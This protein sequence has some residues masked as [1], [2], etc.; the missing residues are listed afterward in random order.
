MGR[1]RQRICISESYAGDLSATE[2]LDDIFR[3]GDA[4]VQD[5]KGSHFLPVFLGGNGSDLHIFHAFQ[6]IEEFLQLTGVDVFSSPD[7][8]SLMRPV[9]R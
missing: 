9:M 7:N 6:V 2:V 4:F 1:C 3:H 5:D 8:Q